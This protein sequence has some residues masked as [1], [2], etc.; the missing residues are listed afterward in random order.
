LWLVEIIRRL[1]PRYVLA[2]ALGVAFLGWLVFPDNLNL[3]LKTASWLERRDRA[4][5]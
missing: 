1:V 4:L 2:L 5:F 3:A